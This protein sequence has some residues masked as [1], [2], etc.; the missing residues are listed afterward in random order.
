LRVL[1]EEDDGQSERVVRL[2]AVVSTAERLCEPAKVDP[3]GRAAV[4]GDRIR[5]LTAADLGDGPWGEDGSGT[6]VG[7]VRVLEIERAHVMLEGSVDDQVEDAIRLMRDRGALSRVE[8][9][10]ATTM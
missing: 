8:T 2:P 1:C 3:E 4:P 7:E 5:V 9:V 6:Y 10:R